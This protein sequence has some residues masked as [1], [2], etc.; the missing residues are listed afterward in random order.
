MFYCSTVFG[1]S[2]GAISVCLH[3]VMPASAGLFKQVIS[4]SGFCEIWD[5]PV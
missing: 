3:L 5:L 1:E 2:A 4:E